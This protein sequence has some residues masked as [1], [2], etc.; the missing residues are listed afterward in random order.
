M[1]GKGKARVALS[2]D[3]WKDGRV[4]PATVEVPVI[5]HEVTESPELV[6]TLKGHGGGVYGVAFS[7]DGRTLAVAAGNSGRIPEPGL[8][9]LWDVGTGR[10]VRTLTGHTSAVSSVA[11]SPDGKLLASGGQD[12]TVRVWD[13]SGVSARGRLP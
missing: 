1:V 6:A 10:R 9:L 7:P 12:R 5:V 4:A 11:F 2:F 13:L 8:V 3:A